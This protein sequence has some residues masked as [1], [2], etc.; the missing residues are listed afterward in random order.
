MS[1]SSNSSSMYT[2]DPDSDYTPSVDLDDSG[3][4]DE[5]EDEDE[6]QDDNRR[7]TRSGNGNIARADKAVVSGPL[8]SVVHTRTSRANIEESANG[9]MDMVVPLCMRQNCHCESHNALLPVDRNPACPNPDIIVLDGPP[10]TYREWRAPAARERQEKEVQTDTF[11]AHEQEKNTQG[12]PSPVRHLNPDEIMPY[13]ADYVQRAFKAE[14]EVKELKHRILAERMAYST[15]YSKCEKEVAILDAEA[16]S[17]SEVARATSDANETRHQRDDA[18]KEL[19]ALQL[20]VEALRRETTAAKA[21]HAQAELRVAHQLDTLNQNAETITQLRREVNQWKDQSKN[22]QDHFLRV[23]QER[24]ALSS[25]FDELVSERLQWCRNPSNSNVHTPLSRYQ[26]GLNG[27]SGSSKREEQSS[28][29][30]SS[31]LKSTL[32]FKD[33]EDASLN[34]TASTPTEGRKPKQPAG[35]SAKKRALHN[36][37]TPVNVDSPLSHIK[38]P[39]SKSRN[40][41]VTRTANHQPTIRSS[42]VIR[43]VQAVVHV[44]REGSDDEVESKSEQTQ[45]NGEPRLR[46]KRSR[47]IVEEPQDDPEDSDDNATVARSL[48]T[49]KSI[50]YEESD[51]EEQESDEDELMI[52]KEDKREGAGSSMSKHRSKTLNGPHTKKR[53]KVS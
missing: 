7:R 16:R 6:E 25:R 29:M 15:E 48:R 28:P 26:E 35:S 23:E 45:A 49:V 9:D 2:S 43:R 47:M 10:Q 37:S 32:P 36:H 33:G 13:V 21:A 18:L 30:K 52:G 38:A 44:K 20:E 14:E 46:R 8:A 12:S 27:A 5:D 41:E 39:S 31:V 11:S 19:H 40:V 17:R 50:N 42:T 53:Q 34:T 4:D 51:F 3:S 1:T 22:W 24:C